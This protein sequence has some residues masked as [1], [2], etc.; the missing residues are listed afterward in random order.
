MNRGELLTKIENREIDNRYLL[1]GR[2]TFLLEELENSFIGMVNPDMKDFNLSVIDGKETSLEA[3]RTAVETLPFMDEKRIVIIKDFELLFGKRK[4]FT[5]ADEKSLIALLD[6]FPDTTCLIFVVYGQIDS[7]KSI[8]KKIKDRSICL[9]L[10]KLE[11]M[12]I[13][14]WCQDKFNKMSVQINNSEVAYF[15]ESS[16]Y[17]DRVSEMTLSD[18]E[19]EINKLCSYVGKG[20]KIDKAAINEML[21]NKSENDIFLF[22]DSI[23]SK[24]SKKAYKVLDDLLDSGESVL[25]ILARLSKNFS[26]VL[27]VK[28]LSKKRLTNNLIEKTMGVHK[29]TLN[30]LIKQSRNYE[31]ETIINILNSIAQADYKIKN[32]LMNDRLSLEIIIAKY[33]K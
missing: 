6:N 1:Y 24:N 16:G 21:K 2:E 31:Y 19:N 15:I 20:N 27:Q 25:G 7:R 9:E 22:I 3:I 4:N 13:L 8:V 14:K 11:D 32:G 10:K 18:M 29:F 28:D 17:R 26:Q 23:G 5:E 30:K 12:E 33:C